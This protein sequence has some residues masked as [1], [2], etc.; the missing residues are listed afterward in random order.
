MI[1]ALEN[2]LGPSSLIDNTAVEVGRH[3]GLQCSPIESLIQGR[4]Q[5]QITSGVV[6]QLGAR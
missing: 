1:E 2:I 4:E 5:V 3:V 6:A